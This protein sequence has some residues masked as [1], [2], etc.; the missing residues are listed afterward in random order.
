MTAAQGIGM[1]AS[2]ASSMSQMMAA[3]SQARGLAAQATMARLQ[4]K[5]ESLKYKQQGLS[6]LDNILQTQA[7][8]N[9]RA[10]A[11]GIDPNS[12]SARALAQ[13]ALSRGA[14]ETYTIMDNQVIAERGGEMQAQQY[15]QQA[16]GV[17]RAGMIGAIAQGATTAYQFGLI[18]GA[19]LEPV[20][21]YGA[22]QVDPRLFRAA[23]LR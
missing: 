16:R 4:A 23:G 9:A 2:A 11:G 22:G 5:T 10:G 15:M 13:Y 1:V 18:G 8:I 12:G 14:Q 19:P 6:I 21:G 3:R 17:M 20:M 7:A